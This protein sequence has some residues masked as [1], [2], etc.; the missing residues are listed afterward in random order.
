M[1][2]STPISFD[3]GLAAAADDC[4]SP[5]GDQDYIDPDTHES[6]QPLEAAGPWARDSSEKSDESYDSDGE[7]EQGSFHTNSRKGTHQQLNLDNAASGRDDVER[8]AATETARVGWGRSAVLASML[9]T[10]ALVSSGAFIKLKQGENKDFKSS[11]SL[12]SIMSGFMILGLFSF[13]VLLGFS[14]STSTSLIRF[15]M[16]LSFT[17]TALNSRFEVCR[18]RFPR[19]PTCTT[20]PFRLSLSAVSSLWVKPFVRK[21]PWKLWY[22]RQ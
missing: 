18:C 4:K 10:A 15:A 20:S 11:V 13:F 7:D 6:Q 22:T 16:Q 3:D 17:T 19:M 9:T 2:E 21:L 8:I 12:H 5:V 1:L 14:C